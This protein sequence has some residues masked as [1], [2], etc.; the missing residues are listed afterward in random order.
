MDMVAGQKYFLS[1]NY[2]YFHICRA[3]YYISILVNVYP[4][5]HVRMWVQ[6]CDG[7]Y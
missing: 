1:I 2:H 7:V 5:L 6:A 3:G 4:I